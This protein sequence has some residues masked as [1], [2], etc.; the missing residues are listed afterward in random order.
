MKYCIKCGAQNN[1]SAGFC[2]ACGERF[3]DNINIAPSSFSQSLASNPLIKL[4]RQQGTSPLFICMAVLYSVIVLRELTAIFMPGD[5][6]SNFYTFLTDSSNN[7]DFG[8]GKIEDMAG[9]LNVFFGLITAVGPVI[10]CTGMWTQYL[11][12]KNTSA[13]GQIKTTGL[14]MIKIITTIDF[15]VMCAALGLGLL[16]SFILFGF[17]DSVDSLKNSLD[18]PSNPLFGVNIPNIADINISGIFTVLLAALII[19]IIIAGLFMILYYIKLISAIQSIIV[20]AST[21]KPENKISMLVPVINFLNALGSIIS[22]LILVLNFSGGNI[23]GIIITI[24][25]TLLSAVLNVITA[26]LLISYKNKAKKIETEL[27]LSDRQLI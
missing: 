9:G 15:V 11:A 12:F 6:T 10:M 22:L 4:L 7:A 21:G 20:A 14:S 18:M 17:R 25:S 5:W 2:A 27:R 23:T 3:A 16:G 19:G 8:M 24:F 26:V 1:D 13:G